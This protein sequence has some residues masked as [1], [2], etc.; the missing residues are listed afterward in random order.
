ETDNERHVICAPFWEHCYPNGKA[1]VAAGV[2]VL[3][4][5]LNYVKEKG[6]SSD[7]FDVIFQDIYDVSQL[8]GLQ[9]YVVDQ[10]KKGEVVVPGDLELL[11]KEECNNNNKL[12]S[13]KLK[14]IGVAFKTEHNKKT[15]MK[16][17]VAVIVDRDKVHYLCSLL[18]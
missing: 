10:L 16:E 17:R 8:N 13:S 4:S 14:D 3:L 15:K 12:Y 7:F 11:K 9:I 6:G 1:N 5:C 18:E 2:S